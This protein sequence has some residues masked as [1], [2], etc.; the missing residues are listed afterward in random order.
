MSTIGSQITSLTIVY[1][2]VYSDADQRKH[3]SSASLAFVWRI[4]RGPMNSP[5]KWP[6]TRKVF[7]FDEVIMFKSRALPS[8]C[9]SVFG[10]LSI[11]M[12][13]EDI[14][15]GEPINSFAE[16]LDYVWHANLWETGRSHRIMMTSS[17]R[18]IFRVTGPLCGEFTGHWSNLH[19]K[20]SD[21]ELWCFLWSVPE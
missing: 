16:N 1:W 5:H 4:H 7:P 18:N 21:A 3:K 11:S 9:S 17:N 19:T 15:H 20:A 12:T 10:R 6:V 14:T 8:F 13:S 2:T